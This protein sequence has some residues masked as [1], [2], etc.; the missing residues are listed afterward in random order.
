MTAGWQPPA[1]SDMPQVVPAI[2]ELPVKAA[3]GTAS[4]SPPSAAPTGRFWKS[5]R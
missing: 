1:K 4:G 5:D 2:A 3:M